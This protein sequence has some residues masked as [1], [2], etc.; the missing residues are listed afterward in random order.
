MAK[1]KSSA[2]EFK[3]SPGLLAPLQ[4]NET[5]LFYKWNKV[6]IFKYLQ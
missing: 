3:S 2:M 1:F 4:W 5:Q 6:G